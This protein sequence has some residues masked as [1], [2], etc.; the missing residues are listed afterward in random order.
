MS[1][2]AKDLE[3]LQVYLRGVMH[4]TEHAQTVRGTVLGLAGAV[5]FKGDPDSLEINARNDSLGNVMWFK[6]NGRRFA[7]A[8]NH[9]TAKIEIRDRS[10]SGPALHAFDDKTPSAEIAAVFETL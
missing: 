3:I 7:I 4:R 1:V 9:S 6:I 5:I 10:Q 2:L 8:Y